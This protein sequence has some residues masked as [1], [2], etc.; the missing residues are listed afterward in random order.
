M[1]KGWIKLHR[2]IL[3]SPVF[4]DAETFKVWCLL[5]LNAAHDEVNKMMYGYVLQA[6][7]LDMTQQQIA[8]V[9]GLSRKKVR[10]VLRKLGQQGA[11]EMSEKGQGK[12]H[13]RNIITVCNWETYQYSADEKGQT[14]GH[15]RAKQKSENGPQRGHKG[16]SLEELENEKKEEGRTKD[17]LASARFD[18]FWEVYPRKAGKGAAR[19]SFAK[20]KADDQQKAVDAAKVFGEI[21]SKAPDDRKQF[22]AHP[23]TWINQRR[24]E[25]DVSEWRRSAGVS[26]TSDEDYEWAEA[27]RRAFKQLGLNLLEDE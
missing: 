16:A 15:K 27:G 14:K 9:T 25:D 18:S 4:D 8:T 10:T 3:D 7:Q 22:I 20:L 1:R 19:K 6:G 11:I 23:S 13:K 2:A 12:G 26:A 24:W 5:L 17:T 21:W